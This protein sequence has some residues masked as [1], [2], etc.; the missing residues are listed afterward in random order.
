MTVST[1]DIADAL[2]WFWFFCGIVWLVYAWLHR[3]QYSRVL[4]GIIGLI[5]LDFVLHTF[6]DFAEQPDSTIPS[7]FAL[8]SVMMLLAAVVGLSAACVYARWRGINVWRVIDAALVC[9][10]AGGIGGRAYQVFTN[11]AYYSENTDVI[12]DL[13]QGG[14]GLRGAL[15][16]GFIALALFAL[17]TH[18]SFWK[19]ADAAVIG[20][21][22]AQSIGWYGA[23]LTHAH[24]GIA[25]DAP[26]PTGLFA[27]LAQIIRT[28]GYNFVQ[29]LPDAYNLIAFR[30]PIQLIGMLFYFA[31][32]LFL[33]FTSRNNKSG[34]PFDGSRFVY[35]ILL[36]GAA[37]FI[38]G[39][40]R[41]DETLVWNGIRIDQWFDLGM[42]LF[43]LALAGG[44]RW[45]R[46]QRER[47]SIAQ[48]RMVQ[49]A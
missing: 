20:L 24:Y 9:V 15:L 35:Y 36:V 12:T 38:F 3:V 49:P 1:S 16:L 18:Y 17:I 30:V 19:L 46:L 39:F 47:I 37:N 13:T 23:S 10:I 11:W 6:A 45:S 42:L 2:R 5:A 48:R 21:S 40:W 32:F 8:Y 44:Q 29:D 28:F 14:F 34:F 27:P 41:G 26:V 31:L 4:L 22:L 25:L 33:L 43:G 7:D